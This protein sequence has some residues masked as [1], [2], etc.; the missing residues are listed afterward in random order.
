MYCFD[1]SVFCEC[2]CGNNSRIF[3]WYLISCADHIPPVDIS[4][5]VAP[6]PFVEASLCMRTYAGGWI[7]DWPLQKSRFVIH[8]TNSVFD[9][10]FKTIFCW[11]EW[12]SFKDDICCSWRY[13]HCN[14]AGNTAWIV[15]VNKPLL[16]ILK[17]MLPVLSVNFDILFLHFLFCERYF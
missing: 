3:M 16:L 9:W 13:Q 5:Q 6:Q 11:Y 15:D 10:S 14:L 4:L 2:L 8:H 1:I 17:S 12:L 7:N